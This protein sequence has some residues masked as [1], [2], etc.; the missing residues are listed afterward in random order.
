MDS[1]RNFMYILQIMADLVLDG[2]EW[3]PLESPGLH[4]RPEL[5]R[6]GYVHYGNRE[7]IR[8]HGPHNELQLILEGRTEVRLGGRPLGPM[9]GPGL[10]LFSLG[11]ET[12][13][14]NHPGL[15]KVFFHCDLPLGPTDLLLGEE[16]FQQTMPLGNT[17]WW[18]R[19]KAAMASPD[20]FALQALLCEALALISKDLG[21]MVR[22]R[23][24]LGRFGPFFEYVRG[25]PVHD[26]S[27]A[28]AA[29]RL[30]LHPTHFSNAF[31]R[32]FGRSAKQF[33]LDEKI[34]LAKGRLARDGERLAVL[35][36][37]LGF[38]DAFHFS[39]TFKKH[40]GLSPKDFRERYGRSERKG[41]QGQVEPD[42]GPFPGKAIP[43][44]RLTSR[45]C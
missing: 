8:R 25:T 43:P 10:Q 42:P 37:D 14:T 36:D 15:K 20:T 16:P 18:E 6:A 28:K 12:D 7:T 27:L 31:K 34:R 45:R 19:M 2:R 40:T 39:R 30:G 23:Q 22:R 4:L 24:G 5:K 26:F 33:F 11:H 41:Q 38:C 29:A 44:P 21:A 1:A 3:N 9:T 32:Q 35:A 13:I 17:A